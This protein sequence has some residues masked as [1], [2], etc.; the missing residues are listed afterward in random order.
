MLQNCEE[1]EGERDSYVL[2]IIEDP[3]N[4]ILLPRGQAS[5]S[6]GLRNSVYIAFVNLDSGL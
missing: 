4:K 2:Q 3:H 6:T 5:G 1:G